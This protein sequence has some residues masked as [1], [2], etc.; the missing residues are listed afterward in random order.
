[1]TT[2]N[3]KQRAAL[4]LLQEGEEYENYFFEKV[5]G[6][7]WFQP[8][9]ELGYFDPAKNP[10]PRESKEAGYY[11]IPQWAALSYLERVAKRSAEPA[12]RSYAEEILQVVTTVTR[13]QTGQRTDNYR[14]WWYFTKF[15]GYLPTDV[16]QVEHIGLLEDWLDSRFDTTLVAGELAKSVV[17]RFLQSE[18]NE[19][20]QKAYRVIEI[21]TRIRW[22]E[23]EASKGGRKEPR[24]RIDPFWL[25]ELFAKSGPMLGEKCGKE[26]IEILRKRVKEAVRTQDDRLSYIWRPAIEDHVQNHDHESVRCTL[27]TALRDVTTA[28]ARR[29]Q[30]EQAETVLLSMMDDELQLIRRIGIYVI[31]LDFDTYGHIFGQVLRSELFDSNYQHEMYALLNSRFRRLDSSQQAQL[32]GI[33]NSLTREWR[34]G[35]DEEQL[36]AHLRLTWLHAIQGQGNNQV[37][38]EYRRCLAISGHPPENPDFAS[39]VT[40]YHGE[41]SPKTVEELL[42]TSVPEIGRYL[43]EFRGQQQWGAPTRDGLVEVL[44]GA[45]AQRPNA[46]EGELDE[47]RTVEHHYQRGVIRGFAEAWNNKQIIDWN[48]ILEFCE[49]IIGPE[50]F[51]EHATEEDHAR[52]H[53]WTASAIA[54]L[55]KAGTQ[56]DAWAFDVG[57]L[58][59]AER[60]LLRVLQKVISTATGENEDGLSEAINTAKGNCLEAL[61]SYCLRQARLSDKREENRGH[62]WTQ[63]EPAFERELDQCQNGNLEFSALAGAYLPNLLYQSGEWVRRNIDRIFPHEYEVN[64]RCAMEGYA[65]VNRVYDELYRLLKEHGHF[66]RALTHQFRSH[67]IRQ[68][69]IQNIC[70]MYLQ[71][72]E[73]LT[74]TE[75]LMAEVLGRFEYDDV[76]HIVWFFWSLQKENVNEE[77]RSAILSFWGWCYQRIRGEEPA[78]ARILS[79]LT[80][81]TAY[82]TEISGEQEAWIL[83][84]APY[85]DEGHHSSFFLEYLDALA[86]TSPHAV[87]RAYLAMLERALP[88]YEEERIRSIVEKLY[89]NG[90]EE[91]ASRICDTYARRGYPA[92]LREIYERHNR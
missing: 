75:S 65:Y 46:F 43:R 71:S 58:P 67:H 42:Q 69:V 79:E 5:D 25:R 53:Q 50:E 73:A 8:L 78:H 56:N 1:M 85:A 66:R 26:T 63:I 72:V 6:L 27:I 4:R 37:D 40:E 11:T 84:A 88:V 82:L 24:L 7:H 18:R 32:L 91:A 90:M 49:A 59:I 54:D 77:A 41:V 52:Q 30:T 9:K 45:I 80:L 35:V 29:G 20:W 51:W 55:I 39:Y 83:Q 34:K 21:V 57:L 62:F 48:R 31:N 12:D 14:T 38:E 74:G 64:W 36:N 76:S 44:R 81:L 60:I 61:F 47:F 89:E 68:K 33:I 22:V 13:P 10:A 70:I 87:G 2:L 86:T 3:A 23:D 16:V 17:P 28:Y 15:L 92:M 19:D